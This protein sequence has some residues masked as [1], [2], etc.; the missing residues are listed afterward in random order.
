M[1]FAR[2]SREHS[3]ELVLRLVPLGRFLV[4]GQLHSLNLSAGYSENSAGLIINSVWPTSNY[5][6]LHA[7]AECK[8]LTSGQTK[9]KD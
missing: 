2:V 5:L 3:I 1:C 6:L 9:Q 7:F 8:T 4:S